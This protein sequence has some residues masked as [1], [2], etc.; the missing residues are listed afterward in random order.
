MTTG[1]RYFHG[2]QIPSSTTL[3]FPNQK[4]KETSEEIRLVHGYEIA[5]I[6]FDDILGT[7]NSKNIDQFFIGGRHNKIFI[8]YLTQSYFDLQNAV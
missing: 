8:Y 1:S 6:V 2:H 3:Q 4:K 7:S 5:I